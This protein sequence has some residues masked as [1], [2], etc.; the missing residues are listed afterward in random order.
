MATDTWPIVAIIDT[1]LVN[2]PSAPWTDFPISHTSQV[3]LSGD[4][5]AIACIAIEVYDH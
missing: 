3:E 2:V 5:T 1:A 4:Q